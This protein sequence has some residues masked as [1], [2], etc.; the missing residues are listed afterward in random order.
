L[1]VDSESATPNHITLHGIVDTAVAAGS[2]TT[3]VTAAGIGDTLK[4]A[5]PFTVF[6]PADDAFA[7]RPAGTVEELH[8]PENK[9]KLT[10]IL[11]YHVLPSKV[12]S[13]DIGGKTLQV[14]TVQGS[15]VAI[16][17]VIM[18]TAAA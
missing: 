8:K 13:R 14:K 7:K 9:A 4:G 5:G 12:L 2:I 15:E 17:A 10:S 1:T 18:P 11:T 16:D 3:L 6:A